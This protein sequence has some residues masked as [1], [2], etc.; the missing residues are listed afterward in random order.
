[1]DEHIVQMVQMVNQAIPQPKGELY[2][3]GHGFR[4]PYGHPY[5]ISACTGTGDQL[6]ITFDEGETL[7]LWQPRDLQLTSESLVIR[8]A[9]QIRWEWT[10]SDWPKVPGAFHI[11][12]LCRRGNN[13]EVLMD[14]GGVAGRYCATQFPA[15]AL[16]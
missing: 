7:T 3:L 8:Q 9:N 15:L 13:I 14:T 11:L 4:R 10:H 6:M 12:D 16:Q 1:M 5:T 2:V